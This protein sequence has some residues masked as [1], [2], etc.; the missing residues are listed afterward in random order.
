M[1]TKNN[2]FKIGLFVIVGLALLVLALLA[3]GAR[4]YFKPR[5]HME[6]AVED[7]VEGLSIGSPVNF[8]GV[9]LG[10]VS[11][12]SLTRS[13]YPEST[14]KYIIL[15]FE[16]DP[17]QLPVR[18]MGPGPVPLR[19]EIERGLRVRLKSLGI[20]GSTVAT[21]EYLDPL[22]F[23]VP[24]IDYTP[25]LPFIPSAPSFFGALLESV[26][27]SLEG[28][29]K[30]DFARIQDRLDT[31][32][33]SLDR[34]LNNVGRLDFEVIGTEARDRLVEFKETNRKLQ[35]TL[36]QARTTM[37]GLRSAELSTNALSLVSKFYQTADQVQGLLDRVQ[38]LSFAPLA[39]SL[40][41]TREATR[42]LSEV[43]RNLKDYPSGF[44][45]GTPPA[46]AS[47][48]DRKP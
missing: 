37:A 5:F 20:T 44:L 12:I 14:N 22:K 21:L 4:S 1:S 43:L 10:Q 29:E 48:L 7:S 40:Q 31:V 26:Q 38:S 39:D 16:L 19:N 42:E 41:N 2:H 45:F 11:R 27:K 32:M 35:E 23:P 33:I 46:P 24:P 18:I 30:L 28:I 17:A 3:F 25:R 9:T 6:T 13:V 15:E 34:L 36:D 8:R 47:V